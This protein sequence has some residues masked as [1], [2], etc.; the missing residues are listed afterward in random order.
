MKFMK[1]RAQKI[2]I[3]TL[4]ILI[5]F[6]LLVVTVLTHWMLDSFTKEITQL[7]YRLTSLVRE[8]IDTRLKEIDSISSQIELSSANL[9]LSRL[10]SKDQISASLIYP[11]ANQVR[12][13]KLA[14]RF[15]EQIYIYYPAMDYVVG[16]LGSFTS[17]NYYMLLHNLDSTGYD[18]WVSKMSAQPKTYYFDESSL[19]FSRQLPYN[20]FAEKTANIV[21]KINRG[22]VLNSLGNVQGSKSSAVT[23]VIGTGQQIYAAAG[24]KAVE[25]LKA[26]PADALSGSSL[27]SHKNLFILKRD[28][29]IGEIKYVTI[30]NRTELLSL[31]N[32][33]RTIAYL[34]L[35]GCLIAGILVSIYISKRN[36]QPLLSIVNKVREKEGF[37]DAPTDTIDEYR[38]ITDR[39]EHFANE[40]ARSSKK[41][42]DQQSKMESLF[43]N[44]VLDSEHQSSTEIFAA[45]QRLDLEFLSPQFA[46]MLIRVSR[47]KDG[48]TD[49]AELLQQEI[50]RL[51]EMSIP[52][53]F[54]ASSYRGDLVVLFNMESEVTPQQLKKLAGEILLRYKE[55][56]GV[57][58][59]LGGFTDSL[60]HISRSYHQA[61]LTAE[62]HTQAQHTVIAY[63]AA[64]VM[65]PYDPG[66]AAGTM[67]DFNRYM[68]IQHYEEASKAA[69]ILFHQLVMLD[70]YMAR[71]QKY[72]I[73][74]RLIAEIQNV[75]RQNKSLD[76]RSCVERLAHSK[77]IGELHH[78]VREM[79][80]LL[81]D[82]QAQSRTRQNTTIAQS[83]RDIIEA[84]FTDPMMGLYSISE[85]LGV[86]N[87][88]LSKVFKETYNQN[89]VQFINQQR[90]EKAIQLI[91]TTSL[92][93]K[94]I[95]ARVGYS[96]D[97]SFIRVFKQYTRTTPGKFKGQ[98]AAE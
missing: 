58:I 74:H 62:H 93:V 66:E 45:M 36:S 87:T 46:V 7:N 94:E 10:K 69:D 78:T 2:W 85:Q 55:V 68:D 79:I 59:T 97:V 47:E 26:L 29:A 91:M 8:S 12:N 83:A 22:E 6:L 82:K 61:R 42:E 34:V 75:S 30:V 95:A 67:H 33:M 54:I 3:R 39:I 64:S 57:L 32:N 21:I 38:L 49:T 16:D 40:H 63:D 23:A 13:Y 77:G 41:L 24:V 15:I 60:S 96:S 71:C 51:H 44:H 17:K 28:S 20:D 25:T 31:A 27:T 72:A 52:F 65:N 92:S 88:Y 81:Q 14:N 86:T 50:S 19:M 43:L 1:S 90:I 98:Q 76:V 56:P 18:Q 4:L 9:K 37:P 48:R 35:L 53:H 11:F 84:G 80:G 73:I 70:D 5:S 89:L